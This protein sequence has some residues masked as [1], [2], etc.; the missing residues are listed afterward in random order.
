MFKNPDFHLFPY[1]TYKEKL[2]YFCKE[3]TY[4]I[5]AVA[6]GTPCQHLTDMIKGAMHKEV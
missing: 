3:N 5:E 1:N 6:F 2:S 4:L